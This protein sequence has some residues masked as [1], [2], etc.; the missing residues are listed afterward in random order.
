MLSVGRNKEGGIKSEV[1]GSGSSLYKEI[2]LSFCYFTKSHF[3]YVKSFPLSICIYILHPTFLSSE[4]E[5]V[6]RLKMSVSGPARLATKA[7]YFTVCK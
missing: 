1:G 4:I 7:N 5:L 2:T 6:R 3:K